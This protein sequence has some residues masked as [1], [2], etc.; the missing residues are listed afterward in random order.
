MTDYAEAAEDL[1]KEQ[2]QRQKSMSGK[3]RKPL[4]R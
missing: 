4:R 3:F 2:E 1:A